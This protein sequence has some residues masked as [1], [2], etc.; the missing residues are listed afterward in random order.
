MIWPI[1]ALDVDT[2]TNHAIKCPTFNGL[3]T[4][5]MHNTLLARSPPAGPPPLSIP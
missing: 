1:M 3:A 2:V 4:N 5:K